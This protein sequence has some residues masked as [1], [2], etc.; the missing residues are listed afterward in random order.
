MSLLAVAAVSLGSFPSGEDALEQVRTAFASSCVECHSG[1]RPKAGL[2]L[3]GDPLEVAG[4]E[5][6]LWLELID[7]VELGEMPPARGESPAGLPQDARTALVAALHELAGPPEPPRAATLRRLTRFEFERCVEDL[8]GLRID[9]SA[10]FPADAAAYGFDTVGDVMFLTDVVVE[11]YFDVAQEV[12]ERVA[13]DRRAR[14]RFEGEPRAALEALLLRAFRRPPTPDEL[15]ARLALVDPPGP[16]AGGLRLRSAL[17]SI[18]VSPH[19]LFRVER[20]HGSDAPEALDPF[21]LATRLAFLLW[22]QGPDEALLAQAASGALLRDEVLRAE[23]LRLLEDPRSRALADGFGAQ[24]LR[25]REMPGRAVDFRVYKGFRDELKRDL[26]EESALFFDTLVREDRPVAELVAADWT[27]LNARLAKHYGL[28]EVKGAQ[29]RR[30]TV[31]GDQ[32]G[33]V[34]GQGSTLT[35]T[36]HPTRTSPV[37]RGAWILDALL[38]APPPPPPPNV[39]A[40]AAAPK[41]QALSVRERLELHRAD[42][43]CASCHARI[44]PLGFALEAYDGVGRLRS[45]DGG[46]PIDSSGTLPG[47]APVEGLAGLKAHLAAEP[48]RLAASLLERLFVYGIGRPSERWDAPAL[49]SALD[50]CAPGSWSMRRVVLELVLSEPFRTRG[51]RPATGR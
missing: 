50:A 15:E 47:G 21:E 22:A 43:S 44:D 36:S 37:L 12:L 40:L 39:T 30:V 1:E 48:R 29:L 26:Y 34:L 46:R 2:E 13:A 41:E 42:P 27:F 18:L 7:R 49:E 19:F 3:T 35:L 5:P 51:V 38:D 9:T 8:F 45:E 24:W 31:P 10:T 23:A 4:A 6:E 25:Y 20:D 11:K 16:F 28:P 14:A 32:R 17:L 33:G